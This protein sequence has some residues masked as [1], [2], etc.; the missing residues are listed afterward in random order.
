MPSVL[1]RCRAVALIVIVGDPRVLATSQDWR[2]LIK[3]CNDNN[4][5]LSQ[6]N[7]ASPSKPLLGQQET[8][9]EQLETT[10][11]VAN[12]TPPAAKAPLTP[13][14]Q[15]TQPTV[16]HTSPWFKNKETAQ[17]KEAAATTPLK[18][19]SPAQT[20]PIAAT[21]ST[22]AVVPTAPYNPPK[23]PTVTRAQQPSAKDSISVP[24]AKNSNSNGQQVSVERVPKPMAEKELLRLVS[25]E[26]TN[27]ASHIPPIPMM[28]PTAQSKSIAE[29][30]IPVNGAEPVLPQY[31]QVNM[32]TN[33]CC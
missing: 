29:H 31:Y 27:T 33:S 20:T 21:Y 4:C 26:E 17:S 8:P 6:L 18:S 15:P 7:P 5:Y 13:P 9:D 14:V 11:T 25:D 22:A 10:S 16:E 19:T 28:S 1:K 30:Q 23:Q 24:A 2:A 3:Y 32:N 12:S